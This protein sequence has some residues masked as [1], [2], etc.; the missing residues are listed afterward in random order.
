MHM[1]KRP[2]VL[3]I[4]TDQ[5][6]AETLSINGCENASTP[7]LDTLAKTGVNFTSAVSGFPLCCP[8]RGSMLTSRY[9]HHCVPGHE[10][11]LPPEQPT[12]ASV[13]REYG[14]DTFY[15]GKWHLDGAKESEERAGTH[16]IPRERRGGFDSWLGYENNNAQYDCY[17]HGHRGDREVEMFRLPTYETDAMTDLMI[18]I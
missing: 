10:Y 15:L 3:W 16:Y 2:N 5:Q 4:I 6:R 9:P 1:S 14:Y 8:Y 18:N 13:F 17:L 12:V 7:V 11:Q